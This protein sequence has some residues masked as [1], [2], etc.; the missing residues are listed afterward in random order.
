[1]ATL[2]LTAAARILK[3]TNAPSRATTGASCVGA[4]AA[5]MLD[6]FG[7]S[8]EPF[9]N[10]FDYLDYRE[11]LRAYYAE[12]KR[13]RRLSYRA[14]SRRAGLLSPNYL[15]LV[16]DGQRNI[17]HE[18][19]QKFALALHLT[20]E[21]TEYFELLVRREHPLTPK[22][23]EKLERSLDAAR[24]VHHE[25]RLDLA[26]SAYCSHWYIPAIRELV[27]R[28]DFRE[29][30]NWISRK[31]RPQIRPEEA[32]AALRVLLDIHLLERDD[33]NKLRQGTAILSTGPETTQVYVANYHR[34]M[35]LR[36]ADAIEAIPSNERDI[37]ALTLCVGVKGLL[38]IKA[39]VQHFRRQLLE[40]SA[41]EPNPRQVVQINFQLFPLSES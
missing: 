21:G 19:A 36:G 13:R 31:L 9:A 6:C 22:Q 1:M 35:I 41:A 12:G 27:A 20:P 26:H 8:E 39:L 33:R 10:V 32:R 38:E 5:H 29:D 34:S 7:M 23:K 18:M 28:A 24:A 37:S 40:L 2:A 11:F 3:N 30:P 4:R 14:F 15:K 25:S 16:M 17:T